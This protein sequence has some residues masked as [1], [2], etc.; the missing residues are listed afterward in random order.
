MMKSI[1]TRQKKQNVLLI[2]R[3]MIPSIRL[4]GH[5]QMEEL[6]SQGKVDYRA[7]QEM[8]I[9]NADLN[10]ADIVLLGRLDSWYEYQLTKMLH[11]SGRYLIYII[12]D[13]LLNIPPEISSARYY[14]QKEIQGYIRG[15]IEM[16]DAILSP[17]PLLLEKY[18]VDGRKAIQIEEPAID[19]APY[20]P[21]DPTKLVKIGFA[22]SIDR[23]S[24]VENIL[25]EALLEIKQEYGD[26][27]AI[28][29]FGAI[30]SFADELDAKYIPYT[31]SYDDYRKTLNSLEWDIGL[32]PMPDT[33]FHACKHYNK[34][35]EY[36]AA[37]IAGIY[38]NVSPYTRLSAFPGYAELCDNNTATWIVTTKK[39]IDQYSYREKIRKKSLYYAVDK[40]SLNQSSEAFSREFFDH[41]GAPCTKHSSVHALLI[42]KLHNLVKRIITH[43]QSRLGTKKQQVRT[44]PQDAKN[45]ETNAS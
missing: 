6:A 41:L 30:P 8:R 9:T 21:H 37:G 29:F 2:Y 22:G 27:V 7:V 42:Y 40:L 14:G 19:P 20:K 39:L 18:A 11:Q 5:C 23:V 26:R 38:S 13:D 16:S 24:D 17:S 3:K 45:C 31:D 15:M 36:A 34:F 12:D 43:I 44:E 4:C 10:W 33:P 32:A 28:E 35:V 1:D 25:K